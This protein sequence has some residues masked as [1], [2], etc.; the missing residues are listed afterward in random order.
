MMIANIYNET[1]QRIL[2]ISYRIAFSSVLLFGVIINR[3]LYK[4]VAK[5]STGER[6]KV[7]QGIIKNYSII[8]SIGWPL[9]WGWMVGLGILSKS[10]GHEVPACLYVYSLNLAI[11]FYSW[12]RIY[13]G[14]ISLIL[15]FGRYVFV[16]HDKLVLNMGVQFVAKI[17][18]ISS[19]IIPILM[20]ILSNSVI[21]LEYNGWLS[22]ILDYEVSC[23]LMDEAYHGSN[24][25]N[26]TIDNVF[27]SPLYSIVHSFFP[28]WFTEFLYVLHITLSVILYSNIIEGVVYARCAIFVF[29]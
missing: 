16:V 8:Q 23:N 26:E 7:F 6:G 15:A 9:L 3:N 18:N 17:L 2:I 29:R 12:L 24:M 4:N 28:S 21:T 13:I 22:Q 5:E 20:A 10:F 11:L 19:V 25:D 1:F 14:L 27:K